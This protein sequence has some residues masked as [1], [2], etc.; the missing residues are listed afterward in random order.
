MVCDREAVRGESRVVMMSRCLS[1]VAALALALCAFAAAAFAQSYPAR[2]INLIVPYPPGGG[3]D[4]MA[5]VVAERLT[6]AAYP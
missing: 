6:A 3:V 4:A 5:R 2:S 1:L